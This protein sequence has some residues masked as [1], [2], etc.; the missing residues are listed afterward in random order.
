[1]MLVLIEGRFVVEFVRHPMDTYFDCKR[2]QARH[3]FRVKI[4]NRAREEWND[5]LPSF[6]GSNGKLVPDEVELDLKTGLSKWNGR[7]RQAERG[8][9]QGYIPPMILPRG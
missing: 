9:V 2:A 8:E 3:I 4:R 1:M 7:S 5:G 6:A